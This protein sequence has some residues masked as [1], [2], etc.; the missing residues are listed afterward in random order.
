MKI[1][2]FANRVSKY[3]QASENDFPLVKHYTFSNTNLPN[4]KKYIY[5]IYKVE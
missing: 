5:F 1:T 4:F 2:F 3:S